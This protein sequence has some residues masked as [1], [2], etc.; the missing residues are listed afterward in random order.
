M[1]KV[2]R[3][4]QLA[5]RGD[6]SIRLGGIVV[7]TIGIFSAAFGILDWHLKWSYAAVLLA[8]TTIVAAI[9]ILRNSDEPVLSVDDALPNLNAGATRTKLN[10]PC[11]SN[12]RNRAKELAGQYFNSRMNIDPAVYDRI[13]QKNPLLLAC[14]TDRSGELLGYFDAIP[15]E[16]SFAKMFLKGLFDETKIYEDCVLPPDKMASCRYLYLAGIA[17][18]NA[19]TPAGKANG[20]ILIWAYL[21]YLKK[22]Y[23]RSRPLVFA[24]ATTKEGEALAERV[25]MMLERTEHSASTRYKLYSMQLTPDVIEEIMSLIPN[26]SSSCVLDWQNEDAEV[27]STLTRR[28]PAPRRGAGRG[29]LKPRDVGVQNESSAS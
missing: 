4:V 5:R 6:F 23:G 2:G 24:I 22:F 19:R 8:A 3:I 20:R 1:G 29:R 18:A 11:D 16:E 27:R 26:R 14:L 9:A 17:A 7:G 15:L 12:L 21:R 25:G 13:F 28:K 10:C